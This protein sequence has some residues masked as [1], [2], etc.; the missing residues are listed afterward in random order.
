MTGRELEILNIIKENPLISQEEL[1]YI[2]G[3]TR[4]GVAAHIHNLMRK[5]YIKG[6]GYVLSNIKFVTVIGGINIDIM[7]IS[8]EK[9]ID[10]NSNPGKITFALGG[11]GRTISL[12]LTKLNVPNY[13]ISVY[14]DDMNGEKFVNNSKENNMDIQCCERI[15]GEHTSSYLYIDDA[16]GDK[17]IGIDDMDIY[18]KMT[19]T[20]IMKYIDR[21]NNSQYC[22]VDTNIPAETIEYIYDHVSVPIIIKT[23]SINKNLR[24]I[25][26]NQQIHTL[27][28]T[29]AELKELLLSYEEPYTNLE[30]AVDYILSKNI[31]NVIVFSL[32]DGLYFKNNSDTFHFKKVPETIVNTNGASAVLIGAVIWGLQNS[33]EWEQVL[34]LAYTATLLSLKSNESVSPLLSTYELISEEKRLFKKGK[35]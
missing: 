8:S 25:N 3:I 33:L 32:K 13:L 35:A 29:P 4:S 24:F 14:G 27:I 19:P 9:L 23:T 1:A 31:S 22:I 18:K 20:F 6:K 11:S 12:A 28:T 30:S 5:G 26:S 16:N 21:M 17:V 10:N 7:G 2:L 34:R 15:P